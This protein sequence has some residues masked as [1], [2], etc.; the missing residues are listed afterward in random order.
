MSVLLS[1]ANA[2]QSFLP[3]HVLK[4]LVEDPTAPVGQVQR[5]DAVAL[6]ADI[7]GFTAM[8]EALA[9]S[10]RAGAEELTHILNRYFI[11]MIDLVHGYGGTIGKFG[12][13]AM[14]VLFPTFQ[15]DDDP[16][17]ARAAVA[18]RSLQCAIEMQAL[19]PRYANIQ[20]SAGTF[21]LAMKAGLAFG[22]VLATL[23][24]DPAV[25]LE[26]IIAGE[27]L[28]CSAEAE[29]QAAPGQVIAQARVVSLAGEI[30]S[31]GKTYCQVTRLRP[32]PHPLSLPVPGDL[33]P[34]PAE[35][36]WAFIHPSVAERLRRRQESFIQEHRL[37]TVLFAGFSGFD[38][39]N[40]PDAAAQLHV[41]LDQVF[42]C[43]ARY[44]GY[45][46]KVDMGDK[47]S[48]VIVL[49]GA[50]IAQEDDRIAALRCALE[51]SQLPGAVMR[52]GVNTGFVF[53]GQVG[54]PAR[55]EYTVMG[56]AVNLA[57]RL[58]QKAEEGQI[59]AGEATQQPVTDR[60][61]WDTALHTSIKG[62][63][64]PVTVY[65]LHGERQTEPLR[66]QEPRYSLP[67]VGRQEEL[68]AVRQRLSLALQGQGQIVSITAE[69][70]M[71]KSR[72][73]AE[74][75]RVGTEMGFA[76]YAGEC[77]SHAAQAGYLVWRPILRGILGIDGSYPEGSQINQLQATLSETDPALLPRSPL[78]A[79]PLNLNI[80]ESKTTR[81]MENQLRKESLEDLVITCLR[82]RAAQGA[83]LI[84]LEDFHWIDPLSADLLDAVSR[85]V[86]TQP[87]AL[88][89]VCRPPEA[90]HA[91]PAFM[92]LPNFIE[93]SLNELTLA[94]TE[95][96]IQHK[97]S[98]FGFAVDQIPQ[99][100]SASIN[101]RAQGNPFFV[102]EIVNWLHDQGISPTDAANLQTRNLPDSLYSLIISR[103]DQLEEQAR[104]T[105]KVASILGRSFRASWL[106]G[107]FPEIGA[108]ER[109]KRQLSHLAELE[110]T[111][112]DRPAPEL[113][114]LF[115]HI[116]TREVAYE[117]LALATRQMLHEQAGQFIE[118]NY[119]NEIE[120][121][122][123]LLAYHYGQSTNTPKQIEYF[124]KA[125]QLA[126]RA[127]ANAVAIAYYQ[128]LLPLLEGIQ[129][130]AV[131]LQLGDLRLLTGEWQQAENDASRALKIA[132][133]SG[134]SHHT[135]ACQ[136]LLGAIARYRGDY[137][138]ALKW[139]RKA[140]RG[141]D[142]RG[143]SPD[144][145]GVLREIGTVHWSQGE[146]HRALHYFRRCMSLAQVLQDARGIAQALTNISAVYIN[147][148]DALRGLDYAR[149]G[150]KLAEET[151]DRLRMIKLVGNIGTIHQTLGDYP[152]AMQDFTN[153]LALSQELGYRL[154]TSI[155]VGNIGMVY[156][157]C[158]YPQPAL[159][160][161][162]LNLKMAS[163]LGDQL[164]VAFAMWSIA[165]AR[166][167]LDDL[168]TA[169]A[170]LAKAIALAQTL[171]TPYELS[172]FFS[173][174]AALYAQME[175]WPEAQAANQKALETAHSVDR[176]PLV[177]QAQLL[178]P[179]LAVQ[180][181]EQDRQ[182]AAQT[183]Q[184]LQASFDTRDGT[185]P[186]AWHYRLWQ[187]TGEEAHRTQAAERYRALYECTPN[188]TYRQRCL[189]LGL[190]DLPSA[191]DLPPLPELVSQQTLDLV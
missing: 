91:Q 188:V 130:A 43:V 88:L 46:N 162:A 29:H 16:S 104:T 73:A 39:D 185:Q 114:Y 79:L 124:E 153:S 70:G 134:D 148:E 30:P 45:V 116:V 44:G 60:F 33:A 120:H 92:R 103:I 177:F 61:D 3:W 146:Y 158:G 97:L 10:G 122:V 1:E 135:A 63:Q 21:S 18:R 89:I 137:P 86:A 13:D 186:A 128:R 167:A 55:R 126:Q 118:Q 133:Q 100:L 129:Q 176:Q 168:P 154:G 160:C 108:P 47:G 2:W 68:A 8:S 95:Q 151:G 58:M 76:A 190:V 145:L 64:E 77:L 156:Y 170:W 41:Y 144:L 52:I 19:M 102:D 34:V 27:V 131:L 20:T 22:P 169:E 140:Q 149:R 147:Q 182:Q 53:C 112:L 110:F 142:A 26:Y 50:P 119:S 6:F 83:L 23:A 59:L 152:Q 14:T 127:Y 96:L 175:R 87:V 93:I 113:E 72:L 109:I 174:Q 183:L 189:E 98:Q 138:A 54:S 48:K 159:A 90:G 125:A 81:V 28:D 164:G 101:E 37:V 66:F 57:A 5:F 62:K 121:F 65:L 117:S 36:G 163:E 11:P 4:S 42:R 82:A 150:L 24:G 78:L 32:R 139:L 123:D 173:T 80:P 141:F 111:P 99:Q 15:N 105:L 115:K 184:G 143:D 74:V 75:I 51:L 166:Q 107:I 35:T 165:L 7:S 136:S 94:E 181:G 67:M 132:T 31:P 71:G 9:A 180:A 178:A 40:D 179:W 49:F 161:Y 84:V 155:A 187:V 25:R 172:D 157:D 38:Y 171:D 191:P 17:R 106:W 12:G 69:A 56:D 85:T